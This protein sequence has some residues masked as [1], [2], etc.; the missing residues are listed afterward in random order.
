MNRQ[1]ILTGNRITPPADAVYFPEYDEDESKR[2]TKIEDLKWALGLKWPGSE[3]REFIRSLSREER[4][5][6]LGTTDSKDDDSEGESSYGGS[7]ESPQEMK[8]QSL[9]QRAQ[10]A[11]GEMETLEVLTREAGLTLIM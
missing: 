9:I 6:V 1:K 2:K 11:S 4:A 10:E 8:L 5:A 3:K 7:H